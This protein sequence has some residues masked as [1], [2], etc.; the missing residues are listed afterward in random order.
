ML[1]YI[2]S[3]INVSV[4]HSQ[5]KLGVLPHQFS[6]YPTNTHLAPE[7]HKR[8]G[9]SMDQHH[10]PILD[11]YSATGWN[12]YG[13]QQGNLAFIRVGTALCSADRADSIH[14]IPTVLRCFNGL[15]L[16]AIT[17]ATFFF[18]SPVIPTPTILQ[19][20]CIYL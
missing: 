18:F 14:V 4:V 1:S 13:C 11:C 9:E 8:G 5:K 2:V 16:A 19:T 17:Q 7:K 15:L 12:L 6:L 10:Q 3:C 20:S